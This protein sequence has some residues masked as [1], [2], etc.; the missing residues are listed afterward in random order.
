VPSSAAKLSKIVYQRLV[1]V[2]TLGGLFSYTPSSVYVANFRELRKDEVQVSPGPMGEHFS[3]SRAVT[4]RNPLIQIGATNGT[5]S[6]GFDAEGG[7]SCRCRVL[8]AASDGHLATVNFRE[9]DLCE[10]RRIPIMSTSSTDELLRSLIRRSSTNRLSTKFMRGPL[11]RAAILP[12]LRAALA[13]KP[14]FE[15]WPVGVVVAIEYLPVGHDG[16]FERMASFQLLGS[17]SHSTC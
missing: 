7:P 1:T 11:R 9:F 10:L 5:K 16:A 17:S 2:Y 12:I 8:A 15:G 14:V 13:L 6:A 4:S 3:G